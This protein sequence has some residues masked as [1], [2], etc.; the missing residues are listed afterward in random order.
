MATLTFAYNHARDPMNPV[1]LADQIAT[2]LALTTLPTVDISPTQI[3]VTHPNVTSG[4]TAAIQALINAYVFDPVW[5][6][7]VQSALLAKAATALSTNATFLAIA[8]PTAA[9]VAAQAK[10]L[11]RQNDVLIRLAANLLD[12]TAGT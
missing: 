7:G 3:I 5:S 11:T 9:Q 4:N 6:G 10:A 12:S 8:S 2:Q 1:Q